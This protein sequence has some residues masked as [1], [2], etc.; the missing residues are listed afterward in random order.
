MK[1]KN[2]KENGKQNENRALAEPSRLDYPAQSIR[3]PQPKFYRSARGFTAVVLTNRSNYLVMEAADRNE[4]AIPAMVTPIT[5]S[6]WE[7]EPEKRK[8]GP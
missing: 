2:P 4:A 1:A 3:S 8:P 5:D 6:A 7:T